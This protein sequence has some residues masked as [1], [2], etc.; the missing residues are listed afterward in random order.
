MKPDSPDEIIERLKGM[1]DE[2]CA[3]HTFCTRNGF[4]E[5]ADDAAILLVKVNQKWVSL[6]SQPHP[7]SVSPHG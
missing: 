5:L 3:L 4:L 6:A 2:L 7:A 1:D